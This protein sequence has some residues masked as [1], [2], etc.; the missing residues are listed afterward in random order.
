MKANSFLE[1]CLLTV[2]CNT[3]TVTSFSS[4]WSWLE[5][6]ME[7]GIVQCAGARGAACV[8]TLAPL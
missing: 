6:R 5:A 1:M 7:R 4:A 8:V 2:V 3:G